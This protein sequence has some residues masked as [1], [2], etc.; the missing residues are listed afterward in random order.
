MAK[1]EVIMFAVILASLAFVN[2]GCASAATYYV[3]PGDSIQSAITAASSGDT[4][5]VRDGTYTEGI[6]V[7]DKSLTIQS[8]NG[9][10]STTIH[11]PGF[12]LVTTDYVKVSGFTVKGR[13]GYLGVLK[14]KSADYC[15]ISNNNVR[16]ILEAS[17]NNTV[18]NN[19]CT[20]NSG[21]GIYLSSS[22]NNTVTNNIC[23]NDSVGIYL[24]SSHKNIITNNICTNNSG[25]GIFSSRSDKNIITNNICANNSENGI[26]LAASL[27]K[28]I[29]SRNKCYSNNKFGIRVYNNECNVTNNVCYS[30]NGGGIQLNGQNNIISSNKCYSNRG[31][32]I[33]TYGACNHIKNNSCTNNS[34]DG[35]YLK[36]SRSNHIY[37]NNCSNNNHG[38]YLNW[39]GSHHRI[40]FHFKYGWFT[41]SYTTNAIERFTPSYTTN[42]I[43]LWKASQR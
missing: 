32:G 4:I 5:I 22:S 7:V 25:N 23:T 13:S 8:E 10:D 18:T 43:K 2:V 26:S 11:I 16:I 30:N 34:E 24:A 35:I 31:H 28:N 33:D 41:A 3:N 38:I 37:Y 17:N 6:E 42:A 9:F 20:N 40:P 21:N 36:D 12:F 29:I 15:N 14:L 1:R 27:D 39:K 19:I